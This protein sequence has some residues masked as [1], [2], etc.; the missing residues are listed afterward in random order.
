MKASYN[1]ED[2]VAMIELG[3][4]KIDH[5]EESE[6]VIIHFSADDKP[7][8]L[9]ILDASNFLAQLVQTSIRAKSEKPV[10]MA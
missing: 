10:Y 9:E 4:Q 6:N 1:R 3:R 2:D 5:A 8:L 7:V